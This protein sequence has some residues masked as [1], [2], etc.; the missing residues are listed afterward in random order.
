MADPVVV[1]ITFLADIENY[2]R[3]PA[4]TETAFLTKLGQATSNDV[5]ELCERSFCDATHT[6]E[7]YNGG[8]KKIVLKN[9]PL[10]DPDNIVVK[11]DGS[12]LD[13]SAYY[14][15]ADEGIIEFSSTLSAAYPQIVEITY[16]AGY[17][18][19]PLSLQKLVWQFV[20]TDYMEVDKGRHGM[21]SESSGAMG[22]STSFSE[23]KLTPKQQGIIDRFTNRGWSD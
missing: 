13:S 10:T 7:K 22:S 16:K 14:V 2:L 8:V 15:Y 5:E 23:R 17:A 18:T 11:V 21:D 20:A 12:T 4:G 9:Y 6:D 19:V 3:L 1:G